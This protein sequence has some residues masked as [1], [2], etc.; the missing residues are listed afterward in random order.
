MGCD[1][2]LIT[3]IETSSP[4]A[5]LSFSGSILTAFG[6]EGVA[7]YNIEIG[8]QNGVLLNSTNIFGNNTVSTNPLS[9]GNYYCIVMDANNCVSDTVF[10][11]IDSFPSFLEE[12]MSS[13]I[14]VFPNPTTGLIYVSFVNKSSSVLRVQNIL[15]ENVY[16]SNINAKG[17]VTKQIDLSNYSN[18]IYLIQLSSKYKIVNK[19]IILESSSTG[20]TLVLNIKLNCRGSVK[21]PV[22]PHLGH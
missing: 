6:D 21:L 13:D 9:N 7:P 12:I 5:D 15:G 18:G 16:I 10:Y 4:I 17:E 22:V 1:S 19:K 3:E 11:E 14:S 2:I 8:N 20:P